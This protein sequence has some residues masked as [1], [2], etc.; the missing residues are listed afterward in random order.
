MIGPLREGRVSIA[1]QAA[2]RGVAM[3][4]G[5]TVVELRRRGFDVDPHWP[6]I[7]ILREDSNSPTGY[8]I[9]WSG[10]DENTAIYSLA[11]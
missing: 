4:V 9:A 1:I 6:D 7:G 11:V 2:Q 5:N 10:F 3:P 8:V